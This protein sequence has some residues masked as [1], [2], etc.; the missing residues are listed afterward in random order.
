MRIFT[1]L[2]LA[3]TSLLA[4][5]ADG[6]GDEAASPAGAAPKSGG[7]A[8]GLEG[9]GGGLS[10]TPSASSDPGAAAPACA[11]GSKVFSE[12][13]T[14][15]FKVPAGYATLTVEAWGGGGGGEASGA[16]EPHATAGAASSFRKELVA[17]G[18]GPGTYCCGGAGGTASGGTE[19]TV[20]AGGGP[21]VHYPTIGVV[22]AGG[23]GSL[24]QV[25]SGFPATAKNPGRYTAGDGAVGQV[26][27]A[28]TCG[29]AP[30]PSTP[31]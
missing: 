7:D 5:A 30:P 8:T 4:C 10:G 22:G 6:G 2:L 12:A 21:G 14:F 19:N 26:K 11:E 13:G 3:S 16:S 24:G 17:G 31:K 20:G 23:K 18:G 25:T 29:S 15:E 27:V 9:N 1:L 28:W